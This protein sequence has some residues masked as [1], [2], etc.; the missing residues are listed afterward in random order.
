MRIFISV[1]MM[2]GISLSLCSCGSSSNLQEE[3]L[4][5]KI[6]L[7]NTEKKVKDIFE[8]SKIINHHEYT[9]EKGDVRDRVYISFKIP[10]KNIKGVD[11]S[12]AHAARI[13]GRLMVIG[14][15]N[16]SHGYDDIECKGFLDVTINDDKQ[17]IIS[18]CGNIL[19]ELVNDD[20]FDPT[21][22]PHTG[23]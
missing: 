6:K 13:S 1:L 2:L 12:D 18:E 14:F 16:E 9:Y 8:N 5:S 3:I 11:K 22:I 21:R 23:I 7:N 20:K 17:S 19:N 10:G 15:K 4:N